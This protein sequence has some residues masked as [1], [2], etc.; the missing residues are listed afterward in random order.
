MINDVTLISLFV[1][2]FPQVLFIML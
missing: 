2:T 1:L